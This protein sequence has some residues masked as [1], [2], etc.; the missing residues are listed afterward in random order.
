MR[1]L[2]AAHQVALLAHGVVDLATRGLLVGPAGS[3]ERAA[4]G[5]LRA[6]LG[7]VALP[8]ITRGA[9]DHLRVAPCAR[10]ST[11]R[12]LDDRSRRRGGA[13]RSSRAVRDSQRV[14]R[15]TDLRDAQRARVARPG[16]SLLLRAGRF[17]HARV[18]AT[19]HERGR[20]T[21]A[22]FA[23]FTRVSIPIDSRAPQAGECSGT[24]AARAVAL[25]ARSGKRTVP[26]AEDDSEKGRE[27]T[28][29][30]TGGRKPRGLTANLSRRRE[31]PWM[32]LAFINVLLST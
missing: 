32:R 7:A 25:A 11:E 3:A 20:G 18:D 24:E 5:G 30:A 10:I 22:V 8:A 13:G 16:L 1:H 12:L 27:G 14:S 19:R 6:A 2:L 9:R 23:R 4:T 26:A 31:I 29:A 15:R 21:A 28:R 17:Y